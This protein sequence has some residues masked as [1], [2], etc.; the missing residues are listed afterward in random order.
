MGG[1]E[2]CIYIGE[3]TSWLVQCHVVLDRSCY[4]LAFSHWI[5]HYLFTFSFLG[6]EATW[7]VRFNASW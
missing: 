2:Q 3:G 5:F 1:M 6:N 4:Q 7:L